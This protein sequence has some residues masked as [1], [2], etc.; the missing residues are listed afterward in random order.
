M[1]KR[2]VAFVALAAV[3]AASAVSA[4]TVEPHGAMLRNPDVSENLIVFLYAND[5]WVVSREGGVATPLASPPG[6]ESFPR[7]SPDGGTIAFTGNYDGDVDLYTVPVSG[8]VPFR[9]THHPANEVLADWAPDGR[10][11]FWAW[12]SFEYPRAVELF[13]VPSTG[14]LAEKLP[15]PYGANAA[16]SADGRWLAYTPHSHDGRTWKRYRGGMATDIWLFDLTKL[17]SKKITDWE[18]TDSQPM[19]QGNKVYYMSDAGP[20]HRLNIWMYDVDSGERR[21]I[22]NYKDYDIKWP[23]IGPGSNGQGEIV[24]QHASDIF[25][26]DLATEKAQRVKVSIPGARPKV[27]V[28]TVD[29]S[30]LI[31][32]R[33]ISATGKRAVVEARGD[34]WTLPAKKG[35]LLNLTR[36]SGAAERIPAWSPDGTRIVTSGSDAVRVWNAASGV[37]IAVLGGKTTFA[38][39]AAWSPDGTRILTLQDNTAHVWDAASGHELAMLAGHTRPVWQAAWSPDGSGIVTASLDGTARVWNLSDTASPVVLTGHTDA[40]GDVAWSPDGT[41]VVTASWDHTA[42]VWEVGP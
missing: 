24:F 8:G 17:V 34:I 27:R 30:S 31:S 25:L 40:V 14:G 39:P 41:Q 37:Q 11:V 23:S 6:E 29:T 26:L 13:T 19:W 35:S 20:E 1:R 33:D 2:T 42:R 9:V 16:V 3:L 18:G 7:F 36:T 12:G 15:V 28:Q 38:R 5:L 22:T 4:A 32:A 21:Q 10:L